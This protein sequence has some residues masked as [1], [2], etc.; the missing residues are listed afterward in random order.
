MTSMGS[1]SNFSSFRQGRCKILHLL[2]EM[3]FV[4]LWQHLPSRRSK[5]YR[6]FPIL[7]AVMFDCSMDLPHRDAKLLSQFWMAA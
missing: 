3:G 5:G 6:A 4:G 1:S 7:I 2:A